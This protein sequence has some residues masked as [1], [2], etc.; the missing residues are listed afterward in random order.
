MLP[1][2]PP[3]RVKVVLAAE[4][5]TDPVWLIEPIASPFTYTFTTFP[6]LTSAT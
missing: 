2:A 4:Y 3:I 5:P 6:Y 1:P